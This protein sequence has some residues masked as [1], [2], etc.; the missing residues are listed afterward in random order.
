[1]AALIKPIVV[2]R[3]WWTSHKAVKAPMLIDLVAISLYS[4]TVRFTIN[5]I[6][7][8]FVGFEHNLLESDMFCSCVRLNGLHEVT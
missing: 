3:H 2:L 1:M 6:S 7:T 8:Q 4:L 5:D